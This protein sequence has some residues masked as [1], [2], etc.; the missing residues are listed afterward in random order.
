MPALEEDIKQAVKEGIKLMPSWGPSKILKEQNKVSGMELIRCTSVYD[1]DHKFAP[2]YDS[3]IKETVEADQIILAIGQK[4]DIAYA[5][6]S[7]QVN[8]GLVVVDPVTQVTNIANIFAGGD[9]TNTASAS[10]IAAIA[11]GRRAAFSIN[12]YLGGKAT[13]ESEKNAEPLKRSNSDYLGKSSRVQVPE[14]P[15]SKVSIDI[16][17]VLS[18]DSN[19]VA[20]EAN[21]CFEC[22]CLGVNPSDTAAA[23]VAL[24]ARIITSKRTI[25]ADEF[26]AGD[27]VIKSTVLENDEIV[28]EIQI[29]APAAGLKSAFIKFALRK[30]IDF[31]IVNCAAA[32]ESKGG[33]VKSA[34]ICLNAVYSKPYR[35]TKAEDAI[36]GK[37]INEIHAEAAGVAGVA[38]AI[39]LPYNNYKIQIAKTLV[40]RAILACQ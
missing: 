39:A 13:I 3:S 23:L 5:E 14:L 28:T 27:K 40:K 8:R 29:P 12:E 10:V 36:K 18:L 31:P 1:R 16:E 30:S 7:L 15:V 11:A 4:P 2:A 24:D 22:G 17:D 9:V 34:R 35:V 26:W 38:D 37:L 33:V 25:K 20:N 21:R 19:S 6:S 32:I